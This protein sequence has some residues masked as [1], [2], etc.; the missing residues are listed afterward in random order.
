[1]TQLQIQSVVKGY[2]EI[3]I[4]PEI[5]IKVVRQCVLPNT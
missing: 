4:E 3:K 2:Q 5:E 1:M